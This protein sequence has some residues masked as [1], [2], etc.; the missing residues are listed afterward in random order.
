MS[1]QLRD[2]FANKTLDHVLED[3]LVRFL[4]NAPNEDLSSS[5]RVLFLVEEAQWFY[6]DFLRQTYPSL[7]SL[8]MKSFSTKLLE[9][10]PL[11]WKWGDASEALS[12]FGKY[13]SS[14]PVRGVA[15]FNSDLSKMVL[16]KGYE[17][18]SWSFPR[19]KI[20]K[21]EGDLECAIREV[22]EETGFS[23]K[24]LIN[25]EDVVERTMGGKNYKIYFARDVPEDTVFKPLVRNEIAAI[26]WFDIKSLQKKLKHNPNAYFIVPAVMKPIIKWIS[27]AKGTT[28]ELDETKLKLDAETKL[29]DLMGIGKQVEEVQQ[30]AFS[31]AVNNEDTDA[32]RELLD[33]LQGVKSEAEESDEY[34]SSPVKPIIVS[35]P[36]SMAAPYEYLMNAKAS[37][38]IESQKS[39]FDMF[40][41][42]QSKPQASE[43]SLSTPLP[44][45][46]E[47]PSKSLMNP[48]E[49]L[50]I[51]NSGSSKPSESPS[52]ETR[53]SKDV[54]T[55]KARA[56]ELLKLFKTDTEVSNSV[57]ESSSDSGYSTANSIKLHQSL[58]EPYNENLKPGKVNILKK[59]SEK[60]NPLLDM[61]KSKTNKTPSPSP[62]SPNS[63][64]NN[65]LNLLKRPQPQSPK[66]PEANQNP[67]HEI[68]G[69]LKPAAEAP[70]P[71]AST[72]N[73]LLDMLKKSKAPSPVSSENIPE[74]TKS[75]ASALLQMLGEEPE[76]SIVPTPVHPSD[77]PQQEQ[78]S[79]PTNTEDFDDFDDFED[80][81]HFD[82]LDD[83]IR[84]TIQDY[85][86]EPQVKPQ[87]GH[88][89]L[90]VQPPNT[91]KQLS[92]DYEQYQNYGLEGGT[93]TYS[94]P[95]R[96]N[97]RLLK[98]G[99]SLSD[100]LGSQSAQPSYENGGKLLL[101]V[102]QQGSG[103]SQ[104]N[105]QS[106]D[107]SL[108]DTYA[109]P[110]PPSHHSNRSQNANSLLGLLT[111]NRQTPPSSA[112]PEG[113]P[114]PAQSPRFAQKTK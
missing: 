112:Q 85:Q 106:A 69:I 114:T 33:I 39:L 49:L 37:E 14:I 109:S 44:E 8:K 81:E 54:A 15:L 78:S 94:G 76:Q 18:N 96:G 6:T 50:S 73:D 21:N 101:S 31:E 41:F 11:V 57:S 83:Q 35:I 90:Q 52:E 100:V 32:G 87:Q 82:A 4:I 9:K 60:S 72:T 79:Q 29:K 40:P 70:K 105:V 71:K 113:Q 80:F 66:T 26:E 19:G 58:D 16:V 10:C 48:K 91:R 47:N 20:S 23:A 17:S 89:E 38:Q 5:E 2:G 28:N 77:I 1:I 24:N 12:K 104:P 64:A 34:E 103:G 62:R 27:E 95:P 98:P 110:T 13:K 53:I 99:E 67:A 56:Q 51:L 59:S 22:E 102:L 63:P 93:N 108:N 84:A 68:L 61:L 65:L 7:P 3:L 75:S 55:N 42:L 43:Q 25:E 97:V 30:T 46:L 45:S 92:P 88:P 74:S 36:Q 86:E 107:S 111:G